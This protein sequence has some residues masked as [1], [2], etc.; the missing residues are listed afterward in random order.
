MFKKEISR[1]ELEYKAN[2]SISMLMILERN[3]NKFRM[4]NEYFYEY[5]NSSDQLF[6]VGN[7]KT[8]WNLL[9]LYFLS[10]LTHSITCPHT[11]QNVTIVNNKQNYFLEYSTLEHITYS[12]LNHRQINMFTTFGPNPNLQMARTIVSTN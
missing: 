6:N 9:N 11:F 12:H 5:W 4:S 8:K 10:L 1:C 2:I 7:S 3:T